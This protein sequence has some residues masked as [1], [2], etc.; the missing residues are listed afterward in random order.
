MQ[1]QEEMRRQ[2]EAGAGT[3]NESAVE[4]YLE[5]KKELMLGSLWKLNVADIEVTLSHVCQKVLSFL[6]IL[7]RFTQAFK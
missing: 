3:L 7:L 1:M 5:S 4:K 2:L 6:S